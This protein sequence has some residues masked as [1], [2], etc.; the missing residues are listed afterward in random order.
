ME[1]AAPRRV[2]LWA[3][4]HKSN[5]LSVARRIKGRLEEAGIGVLLAEELATS[6]QEKNPSDPSDGDADLIL[7]LG[8][9]GTLLSVVRS[10]RGRN[11]PVLGVNLGG[12]GF[13]TTTSSEDLDGCLDT[14]VSGAYRVEERR[15][16][17][18]TA[19]QAEGAD[20]ELYALNDIV[21]DEG[22]FTRRA[23]A[24]RMSIN[25]APVGTF[26]A[27]G[28]IVATATGSTAYS[29][30]ANG[31]IV[32]PRLPALVATPICPHSL[33]IRPLVFHED[34]ILEVQAALSDIHLN[35]TAD[36]QDTHRVESGGIV[37]MGLSDRTTRLAFVGDLSY[38]EILRKKL[39]W[40]GI[41]KDR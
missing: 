18:A 15:L 2:L 34:E 25:G 37:R 7:C 30:S 11:V 12:L 32:H 5:A 9:D 24:L 22:S 4:L 17:R 40:G 33:S 31:P 28:L 23:A 6:L 26:T 27:D 19:P 39:N 10:L 41:P 13:L 35:V 8:G 38:Y 29:L 21:I 1:M 20:V 16:L 3:N 14:V 36:G